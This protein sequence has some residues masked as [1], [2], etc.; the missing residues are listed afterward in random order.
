MFASLFACFWSV[1]VEPVKRVIDSPLEG[2][3][4]WVT[5]LLGAWAVFI[6]L[7]LLAA[8][9]FLMRGLFT[10][11]NPPTRWGT[12][13]L[14]AGWVLGFFGTWGWLRLARGER[15]KGR[16]LLKLLALSTGVAWVITSFF[17]FLAGLAILHMELILIGFIG[18]LFSIIL[19]VIASL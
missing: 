13:G 16:W 2:L 10:Y 8:A 1:P 5:L 3:A 6:I 9:F 14:I 18:G 7:G 4:W 12:A 17:L 15:I 19:F 11:S